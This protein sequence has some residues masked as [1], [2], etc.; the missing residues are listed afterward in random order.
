MIALEPLLPD[1][2]RVP[3]LHTCYTDTGDKTVLQ[4]SIYAEENMLFFLLHAKIKN[5]RSPSGR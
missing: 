2:R 3:E 5:G 1:D 4:D